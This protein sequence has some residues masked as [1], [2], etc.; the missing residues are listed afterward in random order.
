MPLFPGGC[1][2]SWVQGWKTPRI[3]DR[4]THIRQP[5]IAQ[6]QRH[7][8]FTFPPPSTCLLLPLLFP[9]PLHFHLSSAFSPATQ[10][11][12]KKLLQLNPAHR[13]GGYHLNIKACQRWSRIWTV[14][15]QKKQN[16]IKA[17]RVLQMDEEDW[18]SE[19]Q[20][21]PIYTLSSPT[22][23]WFIMPQF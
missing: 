21:E 8:S 5:N 12:K 18:Y 17:D 2:P 19:A 4:S 6:Y 15:Q 10:K 13:V 16:L 23:I 22:L 3:P 1:S 20:T 9:P 11:K 7:L 14:Y